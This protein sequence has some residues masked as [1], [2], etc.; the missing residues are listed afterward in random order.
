VRKQHGPIRADTLHVLANAGKEREVLRFVADYRSLAVQIGRVQWRQFFEVGAANKYAPAKHLNGICGAAPAQM[1][2]FQV[3]EQIDSWLGNCANE[4]VDR[5]RASSLSEATRRQLYTINRHGVW[6]S[7]KEIEGIPSEVRALA[8]SIMRNCMGKHRRPD[9]SN[10][11]PRLDSRVATLEMPTKATFAARWVKLRLPGR[12]RIVL[13]LRANSLFDE[14]EGDVLPVV[15]FC[16]D[17]G[18]LSIRLMQDMAKPFATL[19][20]AYQPKMESLGIDFGLA[21]LISTSEGTMFGS[22]LIADLKRIDRQLV[23]IARHRSRSG[24]KPR[25]SNFPIRIAGLE[26]KTLSQL[27]PEVFAELLQGN[28]LSRLR[29]H[30]EEIGEYWRA[31]HDAILARSEYEKD[32]GSAERVAPPTHS[33]PD[34]SEA[35]PRSGPL[36]SDS[37]SSAG[38]RLPVAPISRSELAPGAEELP[39]VESASGSAN[40]TSA[41]VAPLRVPQSFQ[42]DQG[43]AETLYQAETDKRLVVFEWICQ[44]IR[45]ASSISEALECKA[46]LE[47]GRLAALIEGDQDARRRFA[48]HRIAALQR[49]GEL[50]GELDKKTHR[51]D[52]AAPA[53]SQKSK[54]EILR[55][56]GLAMQTANRYE[57]LAGGSNPEIREKVK[58]ASAQYFA[59]CLE[60]EKT[61]KVSEL[62]EIVASISGLVPEQR[63]SPIQKQKRVLI[64]ALS[65]IC[66]GVAQEDLE[67]YAAAL[68]AQLEEEDLQAVR[69]FGRFWRVFLDAASSRLS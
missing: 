57:H 43:E 47:K 50:L 52:R 66:Q 13:P 37:I 65:K 30:W 45:E 14:R 61:P 51:G 33:G 8:R 1:A 26:G 55:E 49:L 15:Q 32:F 39:L 16:T 3:Q 12:A 36:S 44:R 24:D 41:L 58:S 7:R 9:L 46:F 20:A 68:A 60:E 2:N 6:F 25:N 48:V 11:S 31:L 18:R 69:Q 63:K 38:F 27:E 34:N 4:F 64:R 62:T 35:P 21:T 40:G 67:S 10:L 5:M 17:A 29:A 53:P 54:M 56:N 59:H 28:L 23:A 22:E 19:R 42:P